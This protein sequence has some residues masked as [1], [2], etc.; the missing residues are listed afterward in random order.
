[1]Y[2]CILQ[3]YETNKI[4]EFGPAW[5][6]RSGY[7]NSTSIY[8]QKYKT[9]LS[10]YNIFDWSAFPVRLHDWPLVLDSI[11]GLKLISWAC[12]E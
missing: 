1:M 5:G 6:G 3:F 7:I 4:V 8:V 9:Y 10:T 2:D 11:Y 12:Y